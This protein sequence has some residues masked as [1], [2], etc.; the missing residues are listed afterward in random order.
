MKWRVNYSGFHNHQYHYH[1]IS[2]LFVQQHICICKIFTIIVVDLFIVVMGVPYL[3]D[4]LI[5][6]YQLKLCVANCYSVVH[7]T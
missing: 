4:I 2:S 7:R 5:H 1:D 6:F 3:L